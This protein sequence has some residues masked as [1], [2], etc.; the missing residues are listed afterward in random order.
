MFRLLENVKIM[1]ALEPQ[2]GAVAAVEGDWISC[3][4]YH[5]VYVVI[6]Y[7]QGDATDITWRVNKAPLVSGASAVPVTQTMNIWSNLDTG[8][9]DLLV[10]RT[11]AVSYA[12]GAGATP[13][14]IV[15]EVDPRALSDLAGVAYTAVQ[16]VSVT[17]I[18][19]TSTAAIS[20]ILQPRFQKE[21]ANMDSALTDYGA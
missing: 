10:K 13:K 9:S 19:I 1:Q 20:Y 18:A 7:D 3:P 2:I 5:L 12:S 8:T 16:G 11:S 6:S 4:L 14:Q 17:N 15:L 21:V